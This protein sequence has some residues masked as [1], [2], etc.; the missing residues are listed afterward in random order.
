MLQELLF[1]TCLVGGLGLIFG[2]GLALASKKFEVKVDER[3]AKIRE[4]LP[5]ANCGACGQTGCDGFA[6]GVVAGKC[7]VTG[8]PVGGDKVATKIGEILGVK[9]ASTVA[10]TARVMCAGTYTSCKTKF[11]YS[12]IEDCIAAANLFGGPSACTYGCVGMGNCA[13]ICPFGAIEIIDGLARIIESRC[14]ACEKCVAACP[15]KIIEMVPKFDEYIVSCRSMD[16]G[17]VVRKNCNVGC[18][19]CGKC[20]K[21]CPSSAIAVNG[22]LAKINP[23]LCS[24]CGECMKACPTGAINRYKCNL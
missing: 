11:D 8:C 15:K 23:E 14:K 24:N 5:G 7:S 6:E 17:A 4:I 2:L 1:P 19:G 16:K 20:S 21:V 10:K 22:T 3:V 18:I 9:A 12:G 13:R